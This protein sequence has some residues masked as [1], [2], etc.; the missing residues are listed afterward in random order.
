LDTQDSDKLYEFDSEREYGFY[1]DMYENES[2]GEEE[3][4]AEGDLQ[5]RDNFKVG[6]LG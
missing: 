1:P 2:D 6:L 5:D 4:K 3:V